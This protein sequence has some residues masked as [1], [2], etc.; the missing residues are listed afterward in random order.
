MSRNNLS[1][2]KTGEVVDSSSL[3]PEYSRSRLWK[4]ISQNILNRFLTKKNFE[5]VTGY[6]GKETENTVLSRI[7]EGSE[8]LQKNQLQ[9]VISSSIGT[10]NK[11]MTFQK[12]LD[13]L[14]RDGVNIDRFNEWGKALNFN[15]NPRS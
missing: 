8:Y 13:Y 9:E 3:L 2:Y 11:F 7:T 14:E 5:E 1:D 6:V 12:F 4:G 15:F 10:E